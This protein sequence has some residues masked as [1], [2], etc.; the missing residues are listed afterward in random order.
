MEGDLD[1]YTLT[2]FDESSIGFEQ[3]EARGGQFKLYVG[4]AVTL[5]Y[6]VELLLLR[7]ENL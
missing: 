1:V 7:S 6:A 3:V 2:W 4:C 5:K